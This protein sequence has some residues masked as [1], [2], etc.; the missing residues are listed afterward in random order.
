MRFISRFSSSTAAL[1]WS[2]VVVVANVGAGG[3]V[4]FNSARPLAPG[5]HAVAVTAGGPLT[6]IPGVGVI[7]LPNVTVE[8][9][10]GVV[11]HLDINYGV[12]LLPTIFGA[13]GGHVG[14]T[15]S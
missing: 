9:R 6:T 11:E 13:L 7:P 5:E 14:G 2:L 8:G 15:L 10:H 12:H 4:S 3:C 1:A